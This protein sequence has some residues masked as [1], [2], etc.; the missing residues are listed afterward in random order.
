MLKL[1]KKKY[2]LNFNDLNKDLIYMDNEINELDELE[3]AEQDSK[4]GIENDI[5]HFAM[6]VI[7]F[8]LSVGVLIYGLW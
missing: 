3:L 7:L 4:E 5:F 2:F 1:V 8:I 6:V